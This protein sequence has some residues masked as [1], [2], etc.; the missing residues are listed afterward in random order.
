[1]TNDPDEE[2]DD[3]DE[4]A[5][6]LTMGSTD[7]NATGEE[8]KQHTDHHCGSLKVNISNLKDLQTLSVKTN[9]NLSLAMQKADSSLPQQAMGSTGL[10]QGLTETEIVKM[11]KNL[12]R[13]QKDK[14]IARNKQP[15]NGDRVPRNMRSLTSGGANSSL[16]SGMLPCPRPS[17]MATET[18]H[19]PF[20]TIHPNNQVGPTPGCGHHRSTH[21]GGKEHHSTP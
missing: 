2:E 9:G 6:T 8:C 5:P 11:K 17:P 16:I 20:P 21:T 13:V 15:N 14:E 19:P 18:D 12:H 10:I 7:T 4:N 1:M 3:C